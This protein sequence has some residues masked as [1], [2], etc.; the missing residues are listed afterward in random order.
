GATT[1]SITVSDGGTYYVTVTNTANG[2]SQKSDGYV[3][4]K[5]ITKPTIMNKTPASGCVNSDVTI[6]ASAS[7]G[8]TVR[9]YSQQTGGDVLSTGADYVIR[10]L[11]SSATYWAEAYNSTTGCVSEGRTSVEATVK[12]QTIARTD[13]NSFN[14]VVDASSEAKDLKFTQCGYTVTE[15]SITLVGVDAG[16]FTINSKTISGENITVNVTFHP[17][18]TGSKTVYVQI[19]DASHQFQITATGACKS[20]VAASNFD[21]TNTNVTYNGNEQHPT[22]TPKDATVGAVTTVYYAG[23]A[24]TGKTDAGTYAITIDSEAGTKYCGASK[25][26]LGDFVINKAPQATLTLNK[27]KAYACVNGGSIQFSIEGG[28]GDGAVTYTIN[29][30]T[31]G[32]ITNAGVMTATQ[33]GEFTV[34]A[35]KAASANY[36]AATSANTLTV[37][38][39]ADPTSGN[40]TASPVS[41]ICKGTST[42]LTVAGFTDGSTLQW[43]KGSSELTGKTSASYTTEEL[44]EAA[45]YKVVVSKNGCTSETS[46]ITINVQEPTLTVA[47]TSAAGADNVYVWEPATF[48]PT[49]NGTITAKTIT[50]QSGSGNFIVEDGAN[51]AKIVKA[52][53]NG[54]VFRA[55]FT[56]NLNGCTKT[57]TKDVTVIKATESCN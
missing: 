35:T 56:A 16:D 24:A 43:Y 25:L 14:T 20:G 57:V 50:Q 48:T 30:G 7:A 8:A 28:S 3:V 37:N 42:T 54:D 11:A 15:G 6:S 23:T 51:D 5:D 39:Y 44:S 53:G 22:I 12:A 46:P 18:T 36:Q 55:S 1:A 19:L 40:I 52:G 29:S 31:G 13:A 33:A 10:N 38:F 17:T 26:S 9:W 4:T 21:F 32:S 27:N 41:P 45:T 47:L 49:T 34:Q 2:C